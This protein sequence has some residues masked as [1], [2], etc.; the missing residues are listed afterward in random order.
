M[1]LQYSEIIIEHF[2]HP[3]NYGALAA[4]EVAYEDVNPLCGDR[5]RMELNVSADQ[6][7]T[8]VRFRGDSCIIS[9]A[10]ASILTELIQ[11]RALQEIV[12]L[13]QDVLL[14]ALYTPIRPAR[15]KCAL[16]PLHVLQA[17]IVTYL[18]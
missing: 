11:G 10:A 16:L 6:T 17:G 4:P 7:I 1:A 15:M 18:S 5:I 8:A 13:P 14:T 12:G 3:R 9:R 2:R